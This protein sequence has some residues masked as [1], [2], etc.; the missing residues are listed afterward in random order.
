MLKHVAQSDPATSARFDQLLKT[1]KLDFPPDVAERNRAAAERS[2]LFWERQARDR[3]MAQAE[4]LSEIGP[5]FADRTFTNFRRSLLNGEAHDAA[6]ALKDAALRGEWNGLGIFGPLG[7][8]KSH[9]AA[10]IVNGCRAAGI[11]AVFITT[12]ELL[13][14]LRACNKKF[15]PEDEDEMISHYA[16]M[17]VLVLDDLGKERLT[18]WGGAAFS[19]LINAR[20]EENRPLIITANQSWLELLESKYERLHEQPDKNTVVDPSRGPSIMDR[21]REM[22]GPWILNSAPGQRGRDDRA[23]RRSERTDV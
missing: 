1:G 15:S 6:V 13:A 14:K 18:D 5:R 10:A 20:Y 4:H 17:P 21:I 11:P 3:V 23:R 9:L 7:N 16:Q 19:A 8:G 2:R 22:T 12:I